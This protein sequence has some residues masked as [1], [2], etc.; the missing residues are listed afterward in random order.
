VTTEIA[1]GSYDQPV[2]N[3]PPAPS[4][5][6]PWPTAMSSQA[7]RR[8]RWVA[9]ASLVVAFVAMGIAIAAL[10]RPL[11]ENKPHAAA[12]TPT[13]TD[14]QIADAKANVCASYDNVHRALLLSSARNGGNDATAILAVA[15]SGRQVLDVG[16]RYLL[17]TLSEEPAT[18]SELASAVRK[19]ANQYQELVIK[20]LDGLTNSDAELQP[21]LQASDE[22]TS[23]IERL[24]K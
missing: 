2:S 20:Y 14:R 11:P 15:T 21:L 17:A 6:P 22:A 10:F 1:G 18:P 5:P 9:L 8:P 13:Y 23:T 12:P 19:L 7:G 4:V 3:L 24:C 16:S